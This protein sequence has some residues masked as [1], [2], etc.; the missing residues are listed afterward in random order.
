MKYNVTIARNVIV[1]ERVFIAPNVM[2][3]YTDIKGKSKAKPIT[4]GDGAFIGTAAVINQGIT[5][6]DRVIIG[7]MSYVNKDC[8]IAGAVYF[9]YP[10]KLMKTNK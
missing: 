2:T 1:G 7:A 6:V 8:N 4:I 5:I 9:G 10:V 3:I